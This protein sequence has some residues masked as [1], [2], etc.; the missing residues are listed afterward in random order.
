MTGGV[1]EEIILRLA[2]VTPGTDEPT[3]WTDLHLD[4]R[5]LAG[6]FDPKHLY[7][8]QVRVL[9]EQLWREYV[10]PRLAVDGNLVT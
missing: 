3:A 5:D 7:D 6:S 10:S 9:A 2:L 4:S 8:Q 1:S